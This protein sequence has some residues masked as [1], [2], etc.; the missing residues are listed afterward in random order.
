MGNCCGIGKDYLD[1]K[2]DQKEENKEL[3]KIC[4]FDWNKGNKAYLTVEEMLMKKLTNDLA[5]FVTPQVAHIAFAEFKKFMFINKKHLD[6]EKSADKTKTGED[7][8]KEENKYVTG[9][10]AP[11]VID[12]IWLSLITLDVPSGMSIL[13]FNYALF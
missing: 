5:E 8:K 10:F 9:L 1:I 13:L 3:S 6:L 12:S 7:S 11:P 2:Q 4:N